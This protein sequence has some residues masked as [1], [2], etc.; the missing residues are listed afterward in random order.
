[1]KNLK[2]FRTFCYV[3]FSAYILFALL[4]TDYPIAAN[5]IGSLSLLY[6]GIALLFPG[7]VS[8][9]AGAGANNAASLL[10]KGQAKLEQD[11]ADGELR[12]LYPALFM[13]LRATS[14][15]MMPSHKA[16]R[17]RE[18]R[19]I[20]A[21]Y[22]IRQY[23]ALGSGRQSI[24]SY[25]QSD[26]GVYTPSFLSYT[27]GFLNTLKEAD[28]NFMSEDDFTVAKLKNVINNFQ[29]GFETLAT[30]FIMSNVSGVSRAVAK[31]TFDTPTKTNQIASVNKN[32]A[33]LITTQTMNENKWGGFPLI[34]IC[35]SN[36]F[37]DFQFFAAQGATNATN[38]SFQFLGHTFIN[39]ILM[40]AKAI[41]LGYS[42]GYWVAIPQGKVGVL[43]WIPKQNTEGHDEA[44]WTYGVFENP[45]DGMTYAAYTY[46]QALD[47]T[48]NGGYTQDT[49]TNTELS[50]DLSLVTEPLSNAGET[51]IQAFG[52]N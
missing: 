30:N 27:D 41:A 11:F 39:S 28:N 15:V 42:N 4:R 33:M 16:L 45:V 7:A 37:M 50:I 13:A 35:D 23:R 5:F 44:L 32:I 14:E 20:E 49:V 2:Q 38:T 40:T 25:N 3:L 12:E 8:H 51:A 29:I 21:Y 34:V 10:A 26:T 36:A 1:M 48:P 6:I 18:D 24:P 22:P 9:M 43:D 47:G 19:P 46:K 31:V 52:I 17:T